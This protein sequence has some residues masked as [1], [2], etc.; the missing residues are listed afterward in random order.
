MYSDKVKKSFLHPKNMGK[1]EKPDGTGKVGNIVCGDVMQLYIRVGKRGGK[2]FLKDVKWETFGCAAAIATSSSVSEMAT[3]LDLDEA[4][5]LSNSKIVAGLGG[6]PN[7]KIHCSVLAVDALHEAIY[8]YLEKNG[9][10]I[11]EKLEKRHAAIL[12]EMKELE[13]RYGS[14]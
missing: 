1:M 8:D 9:K 12:K 14:A 11:P 4:V 10:N 13:E 3:G 7:Q 6:L 2:E 5:L